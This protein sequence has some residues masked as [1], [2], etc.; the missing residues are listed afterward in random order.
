VRIV[1]ADLD[2]PRVAA[3][4]AEHLARAAA[5]TPPESRHALALDGLRAA[6]VR[7]WAV[8]SDGAPVG[9]G[10]LRALSPDHGEVKSM[11]VDP[12][13]RGRGAGVALLIH[14]L[15][16]ARAAGMARVSLETGSAPYFAPAVALYRRFGFADCPPYGRYVA[17][18]NSL[19]L[20]LDLRA[21][22]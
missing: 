6:D 15:A 20:T 12:A 4:V 22:R 17:D 1:P 18:P 16:A 8:L 5:A 2:D 14:A 3:L 7:V 10:G 21:V 11:F 13:F 9:V 19:F